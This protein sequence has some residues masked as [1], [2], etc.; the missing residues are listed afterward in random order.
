L[1]ALCLSEARRR[2][3]FLFFRGMVVVSYLR[4]VEL[5]RDASGLDPASRP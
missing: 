4:V 2:A 1:R 5:S 3:V